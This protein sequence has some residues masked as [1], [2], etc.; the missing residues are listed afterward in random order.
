[1]PRYDTTWSPG[2]VRGILSRRYRPVL[3]A[4]PPVERHRQHASRRLVRIAF[5]TLPVLKYIKNILS[6]KYSSRS[7]H[8]QG[9]LSPLVGGGNHPSHSPFVPFSL[10]SL[11]SHFPF[12]T[13]FIPSLSVCSSIYL[14]PFAFHCLFLVVARSGRALKLPQRVWVP[15]AR[16]THFN[17]F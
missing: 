16:Q 14:S 2:A 3:Y 13:P 4:P 9:R 8:S 1:M 10:S 5:C 11:L 17:T 7:T 15:D 12:R 6:A